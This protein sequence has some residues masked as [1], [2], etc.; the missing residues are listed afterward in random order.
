MKEKA[1]KTLGMDV[2]KM[3]RTD[4]RNS[5]K[6]ISLVAVG[7]VCL[8][9]TVNKKLDP[10]RYVSS[11]IKNSTISVGN[12]E[13]VVTDKEELAGSD[14]KLKADPIVINYLR[15]FTILGH[16]NNHTLDCGIEGMKD[17]LDALR[18]NG[19]LTLGSGDNF[20]QSIRP[21]IVEN[22]SLR[23]AFISFAYSFVRDEI[24]FLST[25]Q[26]MHQY[27]RPGAARYFK[28]D[29]LSWIQKLKERADYI[30]AL[31][32]WNGSIN[33][34]APPQRLVAE[35][36]IDH[37]VNVVFGHHPHHVQGI[38]RY[39]NG[40]I[41]YSLGNFVFDPSLAGS[42]Y[43]LMVKLSLSAEGIS[44]YR[45][46]PISHNEI[47]LPMKLKDAISFQ[48]HIYDISTPLTYSHSEYY[49]FW[50]EHASESYLKTYCV[51][52][53]RRLKP[54]FHGRIRPLSEKLCTSF[55]R[56]SIR[57]KCTRYNQLVAARCNEA[58]PQANT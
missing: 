14:T 58:K 42:N 23:I 30:V 32:H 46:I 24:P 4:G 50:S 11:E 33:Y 21:I 18:T 28:K 10:F 53:G 44:E 6:E 47:G 13:C 36:I 37:G 35:K 43:G 29:V 49:K 52:I 56:S 15:A 54:L 25:L 31:I 57:L 55:L 34:P 40:L 9:G 39:R 2:H 19:I 22:N 17:T 48:K 27:N 7:D 5:K 51:A 38:Q 26:R 20:Q 12:L 45:L 3:S 16:A 41:F 8:A 1:P